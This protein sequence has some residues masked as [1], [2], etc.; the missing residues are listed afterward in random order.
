[1]GLN[2]K[3]GM[4]H[5][6]IFTIPWG[7]RQK[8]LLP[9]STALHLLRSH[10]PRNCSHNPG[11]VRES[12]MYFWTEAFAGC[13]PPFTMVNLQPRVEIMEFPA[14]PFPA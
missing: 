10:D 5:C 3:I 14:W 6:T 7:M 9:T 11:A 8:H 1:M 4:M 2:S 12:N 13:L